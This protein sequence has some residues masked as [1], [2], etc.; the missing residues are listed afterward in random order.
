MDVIGV[1][2][3]HVQRPVRLGR[4]LAYLPKDRFALQHPVEAFQRFQ[5]FARERVCRFYLASSALAF[6]GPTLNAESDSP[7]TILFELAVT[8]AREA[9]LILRLMALLDGP[10]PGVPDHVARALAGA[11]EVFG[12]NAARFLASPHSMLGHEMPI[13]VAQDTPGRSAR[14][15]IAG[16]HNPRH[17]VLI[18]R[19]QGAVHLWSLVERLKFNVLGAFLL[20]SVSWRVHRTG[21]SGRASAGRLFTDL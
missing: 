2:P 4:F 7:D 9:E 21:G 17:S 1:A 13:Q 6:P 16:T 11:K 8:R 14:G 19:A 10:A 18:S 5:R 15:A 20:V 12:Q 3:D